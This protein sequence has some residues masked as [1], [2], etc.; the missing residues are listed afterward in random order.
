MSQPRD[1]LHDLAAIEEYKIPL[2]IADRP[3][4]TPDDSWSMNGY[5]LNP[6]ATSDLMVAHMLS[7]AYR[8]HEAD[9][10]CRTHGYFQE[11]TMQFMGIGLTGKTA[12]LWGLGRVARHAVR[13]LKAMDMTVLYNKR[14]RLSP[15]EEEELGIEWVADKDELIA[16]GDFVCMLVN[17]TD[18]NLKLMGEREFGLM[19]PS[20]YFINVA[21]GRLVDEDALIRALQN[22]TIAG[23]GLEVFWSE[24]PISN[25]PLIPIELRQMENVVL[26][27][28]NGGAT[29]DSRSAQFTAVADKIVEDIIAR[30]G[31]PIAAS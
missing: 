13:K 12:S 17:Y 26:T 18:E 9:R 30:G 28:H 24:P 6:R 16:R 4:P 7:L 27:P 8:V 2:L 21:R 23:A 3:E 29:F 1:D 14:T 20:A 25:D 11:M 31:V 15:E 10:F 22:K 5:G 19:K